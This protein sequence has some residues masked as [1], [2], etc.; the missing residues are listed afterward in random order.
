MTSPVIQSPAARA[1]AVWASG[2]YTDVAARL[3]PELGTLLVGAAGVRP[4]QRVLDVAAGNG[5]AAISAAAGAGADVVALDVCPELL[6]SGRAAA[7]HRGAT[8]EWVEGDAAE[9]PFADG[10]F[11]VVLSCLGAM[12]VPD[13]ERAAS[14]LVRVCRPGGTIALLSWTP[15]GFLGK[16]LKTLS[17]FAAPPPPGA[18]SPILWGD[19]A[20]LR[21]LFGTSVM[22]LH[23][24]T[25]IAV[26]ETFQT[27]L[28]FREY[29][30]RA[31]GPTI[32]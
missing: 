31:Y 32:M 21:S 20:H 15:A 2:D 10:A 13:H 29:M 8:L 26:N 19:E 6:E 22:R 27:P 11:D 17:G 7:A 28:E 14:E 3:V 30:K 9:L 25:G 23:T 24:R 5:S 12:F 1:R 16:M 18:Q 4:G